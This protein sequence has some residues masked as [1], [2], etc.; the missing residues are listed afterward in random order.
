MQCPIC[1]S[2]NATM[3]KTSKGSFFG[4]LFG[5]KAPSPRALCSCLNCKQDWTVDERDGTIWEVER[6]EVAKAREEWLR[7][8]F[9][10]PEI[11]C[12]GYPDGRGAEVWG[13]NERAVS[14]LKE[15]VKSGRWTMQGKCLQVPSAE[16]S[17]IVARASKDGLEVK[18]NN[19]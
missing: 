12:N 9:V 10:G 17:Q 18:T 5:A 15:N 1:D 11:V 6:A 13:F 19:I 4:S 2:P 7:R 14:W 16:V 8:G 3:K